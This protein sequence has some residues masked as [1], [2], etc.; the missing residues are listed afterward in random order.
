MSPFIRRSASALSIA[1][2]FSFFFV[3][4]PAYA[5]ECG[6]G[7]IVNGSFESPILGS[8]VA[9]D[10][11]YV[12]TWGGA[13]HLVWDVINTPPRWAMVE[14][15]P[16]VD[17]AVSQALA[18]SATEGAVEI[19]QNYSGG[20]GPADAGN[21]WAEITGLEVSNTLYQA[22]ET[23]P[24]TVM[25]WT[26]AHRG[27]QGVDVMQVEIGATVETL[28]PQES[29]PTTGSGV[30]NPLHISDGT[31]WRT[32]TGTYTV[33]AGQTSTVFGFAGVSNSTADR[34]VGN[35]IDDIGFTCDVELTN[36]ANESSESNGGTPSAGGKL[37]STGVEVNTLSSLMTAGL[38]LSA[39]ASAL[40]IARRR[41][42]L[43]RGN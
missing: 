21:Q 28:V 42:R 1:T 6:D 37:A 19:Q 7:Q 41:M 18:W 36:D 4:P 25:T 12:P 8:L 15:F 20:P 33:P 40:F 29:T 22:V 26:L 32:W 13:P 38:L 30:S 43:S 14:S 10:I 9:D 3:A 17:T 34:T 23:V 11:I 39:S 31:T 2:A 24:G 35:L 5:A 27:L 16:G